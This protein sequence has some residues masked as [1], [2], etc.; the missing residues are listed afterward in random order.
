M[1]SISV[2]AGFDEMQA[3]F[4]TDVSGDSN[5]AFP[6]HQPELIGNSRTFLSEKFI[7]IVFVKQALRSQKD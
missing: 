4:L 7:G 2:T 6:L 1:N 3:V 5:S